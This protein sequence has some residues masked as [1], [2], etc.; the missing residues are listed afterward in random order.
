MTGLLELWLPILLSAVFCFILSSIIHMLPLW[1]RTDYPGVPNQDAVMDA[2]RPFGIAP[3]DYMVPRAASMKDYKE[4]AFQEKMN[5][6]PLLILTVL[7]RSAFSMGRS[8]T[9]WFVY[10]VIVGIL[11]A[12]IAGRAL[13]HGADYLDVFRFAGTTAFIAY[14]VAIWQMWIWYHRGLGLTIKATFDGLLYALLTAGVFGW[15]W[16]R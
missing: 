5:K 6:G 12:Y 11:A 14:T 10:L 4:P 7:R 13:P 9:L 2:M 8:L 16:P 1:H 3:G 15:L